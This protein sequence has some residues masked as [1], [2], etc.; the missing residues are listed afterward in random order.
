[1]SNAS[2]SQSQTSNSDG[3]KTFLNMCSGGVA[4]AVSR[5]ATSPIERLKVL[6]QV[7]V[8][9]VKTYSGIY[10]GL[11]AIY[12]KEGWRGYFKGMFLCNVLYII[13]ILLCII[14]NLMNLK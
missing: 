12:A 1:M 4:G 6:Q 8:N 13:E 5:T 7:Q 2:S 10:N 3:L 14:I 9:G 11:S